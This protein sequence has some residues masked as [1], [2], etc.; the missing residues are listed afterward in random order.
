MLT[1]QLAIYLRR[2]KKRAEFP[3]S[4]E[5]LLM[6]EAADSPVLIHSGLQT[7]IRSFSEIIDADLV[8]KKCWARHF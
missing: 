5:C 2:L 8:A 1:R 4:L 6:L 7:A 3:A